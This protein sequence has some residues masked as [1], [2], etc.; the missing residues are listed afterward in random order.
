MNFAWFSSRQKDAI[1]A[2]HYARANQQPVGLADQA[3]GIYPLYIAANIAPRVAMLVVLIVLTRLLPA[4]EYG[5]FALVITAGEI[6]EMASTNWIRV[7][8]L[9][10]EAGANNLRPRRLGRALALSVGGTFAGLATSM[11]VVPFISADRTSEM[12]LA[13]V[14][15]IPAFALLRM[16]LTLAQL[17]RNHATYATIECGRALGI[18]IV[19]ITGTMMNSHSFLSM[20][21]AL[22]LVAAG[23][24]ALGLLSMGRRLP[25]PI[26]PRGGYIGA[27]AFGVPFLLATTLMYTISWFDR[28]IV[29]YFLGP[30]L[31]G[32]YVAAYS[33]ARQPV[34]LLLGALNSFT[35]PLLVHTYA[36]GGAQQ[37]GTVQSGLLTTMTV[38]GTG[39]VA[40]LTLLADPLATLLFP[41]SYRADVASLIPW[42]AAAT[43]ALSIKQF[44]FDN[45]LHAT[46]QN[47]A[48][49]ITMIPPVLVSIGFGILLIRGQG[50][51]G[52]AI[53]SVLVSIV[54]MLSAGIVSFRFF[55]FAVPWRDLAKV[56][57]AVLVTTAAT[58]GLIHHFAWNTPPTLMVGAAVFCAIYSTLLTV[59]GFS[60]LRLIHTPWSP[61]GEA[62]KPTEHPR[63]APRNAP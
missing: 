46:Q 39:I 16:T 21:V 59:L 63:T 30:T 11:L 8:L 56:A 10:T 7:Y 15:Y 13:V 34:E 28:F 52:A 40:G 12:M 6:L 48:L 49:V 33:I 37:A 29:N 17:S 4:A 36:N 51:F 53:N 55:A 60:F 61:L 1:A 3:R 25:R 31:V 43:F 5:L 9:R 22:S 42:I 38:V 32:I 27:L 57:L 62:L 20:S 23:S 2:A 50:L 14:T 41:L 58:W 44:V 54:A 18:V 47:W 26:F 24:A 45:G 35:F 19:T